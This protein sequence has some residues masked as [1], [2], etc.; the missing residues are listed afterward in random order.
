MNDAAS[1]DQTTTTSVEPNV[2]CLAM[3]DLVLSINDLADDD[4][5]WT[6]TVM[7]AA[8]DVVPPMTELQAL[9][10]KARASEFDI[11]DDALFAHI[12]ELIDR[13]D[14]GTFDAC[15]VPFMSAVSVISLESTA[16]EHGA[17]EH[18]SIESL[19]CFDL[20][21]DR[22]QDQDRYWPVD[23][24]TNE[25][26]Y[27]SPDG[28]STSEFFTVDTTIPSATT[29]PPVTE[30]WASE[31]SDQF[32]TTMPARPTPDPGV[33]T[34]APAWDPGEIPEGLFLAD[35]YPGK[36]EIFESNPQFD[37]LGYLVEGA[38]RTTEIWM[39]FLPLETME[40][41]LHAGLGDAD[42][43]WAEQ[44]ARDQ[45]RAET[46]TYTGAYGTATA[47]I[48]VHDAKGWGI[49]FTER[50]V[51]FKPVGTYGYPEGLV[52]SGI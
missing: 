13:I 23:C 3:V 4:D 24:D 9:I 19:P 43:A 37:L 50:G 46:H 22:T 2:A 29:A 25:P 15:G 35:T 17:I 1:F 36:A 51:H 30:S 6:E 8:P 52:V 12:E 16:I 10:D 49:V 21:P 32:T 39:A 20:R 33:A 26:V 45:L 48:Y 47:T 31:P 34:S 44:L 7:G 42:L 14:D 40:V 5:S 27:F 18:G 28:W 38:P 41:H 11:E